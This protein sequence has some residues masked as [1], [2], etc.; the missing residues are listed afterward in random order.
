MNATPSKVLVVDDDDATRDG[1]AELLTAAG[2]LTRA[3]GTFEQGLRILRT[4]PPDLLIADVRLGAYNGLQLV[5]SSQRPVPAIVITGFDDPVLEADARRQGAD[6][7]LKPVSPQ[8]ILDMVGRRLAEVRE[9]KFETLRR[10]T[11]KRVPGGILAQIDDVPAR[12][13]DI[14]YGGM[15]I[16]VPRGGADV[17]PSSLSLRLLDSDVA[18]R[19]DV[20]WQTPLDDERW[21]CG[22]A[23]SQTNVA[24]VREWR[25]LVDAVA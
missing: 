5:L 25:E 21:L 15:R 16:E 18:V 14:S 9:S 8:V 7:V 12:I 20:I 17:A 22:A 1:L 23:V 24:S 4:D 2:Y 3:V 19:A 6:Y 11:R 13:V 10:W